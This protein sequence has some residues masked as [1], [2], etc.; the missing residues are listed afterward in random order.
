MK[1]EIQ[2]AEMKILLIAANKRAQAEPSLGIGYLAAYLKKYSKLK[3]EIKLLNYMPEDITRI[4]DYSFDII[5]LS[6]LTKQYYDAIAFAQKLKQRSDTTIIIGGHHISIVPESFNSLFHLAC[7]GE[8]EQTFLEFVEYFNEHHTDKKGLDKIN[9]LLF[10]DENMQLIKTQPRQFTL[11]LDKIP[12]PSRELYNMDFILN[13]DKN[14]FGPFFGRGTHM[15]TS[16]GCPFKCVFCSAMNFWGNIRYNSPEYVI[17]E[18]RE[19]VDVY[20]VKLIH[21]FDDLFVAN[22]KRLRAIIEGIKKEEINKKVAFGMFGRADIFDEETASLLREMNTVF[23]QFGIESG[24]QRILD[25]LKQGHVKLNDIENAIALCK[26][27]DIKTGGTFIIGSPGE[28][29]EEMLTTLDFVKKLKLDK[30]CFYT[31]NPFPGTPLW[32]QAVKEKILPEKINWSSYEM[33]KT[34]KLSIE[35]IVSNTGQILIDNAI[36]P[37]RFI[38]IFDL[39]EKE[40]NKYNVYNWEEVTPEKEPNDGINF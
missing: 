11:P 32:E 35:D 38:E 26:K 34:N 37:D 30:F 28:T 12:P 2:K 31:L 10:F 5:G 29:Y 3:L 27:Y 25:Y 9:G 7:I 13:E 19:L 18:I 21:V 1:I 17:N 4:V 8:G 16:R 40:R 14:V 36:S 20:H 39:F 15:F 24:I 6:V 22:K 33:K 23:V